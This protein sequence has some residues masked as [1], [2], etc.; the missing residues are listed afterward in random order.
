MIGGPLDCGLKPKKKKREKFQF[1]Q[2]LSISKF[3]GEWIFTYSIPAYIYIYN[4]S[5]D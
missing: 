3:I 4:D 5:K 1:T 2:N